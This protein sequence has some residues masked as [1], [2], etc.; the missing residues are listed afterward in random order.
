MIIGG[1]GF[2]GTNLAAYLAE[3][4][5]EVF[6]FD[7]TCPVRTHPQVRYMQGD[8]FDDL[9][10]KKAV[11]GMDVVYHAL[12]TI[13]PGNS[14]ETYMMGYG[15]DFMQ[16]VKLC[17]MLKDTNTRM[18]F[19][20]S[21][22][23]V[24]GHQECQPIR[25]DAVAAPI[26]HYGNVKLSIENAMRVFDIQA[27]AKMLIARISNP[28]GPGQD[29]T[30]GVGFVDAALKKSMRRE[31]I[32]IW[33]NGEIIR[34]YI[35]IRDVCRML[36]ALAFYEGP[37]VV[38]NI[39]SGVGHTQNEILR[40][41]RRLTG[42]DVKFA[43]KNARSVDVP[44]IV[45]DNAKIRSVCPTALLTVEEGILEYMRYLGMD[46]KSEKEEQ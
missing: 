30:K 26:N 8:F 33:G 36:Y 5:M 10:L 6:S 43:Y 34:D 35:Y 4:Q 37:E 16:T 38:F 13:N 1:S 21:G 12:S 29:F 31:I 24:Y 42:L 28:Y 22:G 40:M 14:N 23:T 20:S 3:K 15:R 17:A 25:E 7:M 46:G 18:I 27:E 44:K 19:L 39:S 2:I 45:L 11:R 41:V 9:T 32:E